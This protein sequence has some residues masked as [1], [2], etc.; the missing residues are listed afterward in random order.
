MTLYDYIIQNEDKIRNTPALA[1]IATSPDDGYRF[2]EF[3]LFQSSKDKK[4][5]YQQNELYVCEFS[6]EYNL[7]RITEVDPENFVEMTLDEYTAKKKADIKYFVD[8][9]LKYE[10]SVPSQCIAMVKED[11]GKFTYDCG[12]T[13][14]KFIGISA[15]DEDYYYVLIDKDLKLT[16]S[17]CV[18]ALKFVPESEKT[19]E[20]DKVIKENKDYI[21]QKLENT[22]DY[23]FTDII[24]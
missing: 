16:G 19:Q 2:I 14:K 12:K 6:D 8:E 23:Y 9:K 24:I 3:V 4:I 22:N 11:G 17:S 21:L 13:L 20:L 18:G 10:K 7:F 5:K 15:T 1:Y